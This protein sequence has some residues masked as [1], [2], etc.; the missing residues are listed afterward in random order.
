VESVS[1]DPD[2]GAC[3]AKGTPLER[4]QCFAAL[5]DERDGQ[6]AQLVARLSTAEAVEEAN[7]AAVQRVWSAYR[8]ERCRLEGVPWEGGSE[9][10]T[11]IAAC[12]AE[13]A[14]ERLEE[15]RHL[16]DARKLEADDR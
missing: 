4:A 6:I 12:K 16:D 9:Q 3:G 13:R 2:R 14:R 15:L 1:Q 8:D 11:I 7:V 5:R 10:P